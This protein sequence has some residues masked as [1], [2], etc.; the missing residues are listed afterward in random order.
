MPTIKNK[1]KK[2]LQKLITAKFRRARS[3]GKGKGKSNQNTKNW[4]KD[5]TT[6][7]TRLCEN[8][9]K[10]GKC[11][12][13]GRCLFAH[14]SEQLRHNPSLSKPSG[15]LY[16]M[17]PL[18]AYPP[19]NIATP[20]YYTMPPLPAG[21]PLPV[22]RRRHHPTYLPHRISSVSEPFYHTIPNAYNVPCD[23]VTRN[24]GSLQLSPSNSS[25]ILEFTDSQPYGVHRPEPIPKKSRLA[26][27]LIHGGKKK[28]KRYI[29]Y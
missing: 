17:P 29:K 21:P 11:P 6:Y 7:K 3:K 18:P 23:N 19:S 28:T 8:F 5:P 26:K 27:Y 9:S 15:P 22:S 10:Y 20:Q 1:A 12:Y 24:I 2:K 4:L 14:G 13:K 25:K 16:V